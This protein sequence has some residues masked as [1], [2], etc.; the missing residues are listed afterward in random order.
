MFTG[1]TRLT[2]PLPSHTLAARTV[3]K[4]LDRVG[5]GHVTTVG[6]LAAAARMPAESVLRLASAK[7]VYRPSC[8]PWHRVVPDNGLIRPA[9]TDR[10]GYSQVSLLAAEGVPVSHYGEV[11]LDLCRAD[12]TAPGP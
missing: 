11:M 4:L 6:D 2:K 3:L 1:A 9:Q 10:D 12:L 7:T 5:P 8:T